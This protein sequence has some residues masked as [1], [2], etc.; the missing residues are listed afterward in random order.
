MKISPDLINFFSIISK[1][2]NVIRFLGKPVMFSQNKYLGEMKGFKRYMK[3][4]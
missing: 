4:N 1:G 3:G 2:E